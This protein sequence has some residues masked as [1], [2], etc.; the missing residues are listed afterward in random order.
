MR[1]GIFRLGGG[2]GVEI[3]NA[4][5]LTVEELSSVV[6]SSALDILHQNVIFLKKRSSSGG[7]ELDQG[8]SLT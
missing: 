8:S 4:G 3:N 2:W 7:S 5:S 6:G 1:L